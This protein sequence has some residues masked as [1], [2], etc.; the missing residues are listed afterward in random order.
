MGD[1]GFQVKGANVRAEAEVR[2]IQPGTKECRG[3]VETGKDKEA[4]L[5]L[6]LQKECSLARTLCSAL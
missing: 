3:L 6:K 1:K 5:P 2:V 4:N